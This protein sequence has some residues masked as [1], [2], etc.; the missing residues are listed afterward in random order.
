MLIINAHIV[1]QDA[2]RRIFDQGAILLREGRIAAL[3]ETAQLLRE[4]PEAER[5]DAAGKLVIPGLIDAHHHP[6]NY[7]VGGHGDDLEVS[8]L[9]YRVFYPFERCVS[10]EEVYVG[11][12]AACAEMVRSGVTCFND[13]GGYMP[14]TI[15]R[16][17]GD[18]GIRGIVNR[19]T[20]DL[21]ASGKPGVRPESTSQALQAA[22]DVVERWHGRHGGRLRA[23]FG[24]RMPI[25][26]SDDLIR[27]IGTLAR[28]YGVGVHTHAATA[29]FERDVSLKLFGKRSLD[30]YRDLGLLGPNVCAVHMG[31]LDDDEISTVV[32]SGL[33]VAHCPVAALIGAWGIMA[34]GRIPQLMEQGVTVAIGSDTNFGSGTL[35]MF[36]QMFVCAT[37][38][39]ESHRKPALVG[40]AKA[41]DMATIDAARAMLWEDEIGSLE[42]GKRADLV[43]VDNTAIEWCYPG[44][45]VVRSLVYSGSRG[46]VHSV[47]I[48]GRWVLRDRTLLTCDVAQLKHQVIDAGAAWM[49][50]SQTAQRN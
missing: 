22:V 11:A 17:M 7:L 46:D 10:E 32:Q 15:A 16:A 42:V 44:R 23:W 41:L 25:S 5:F 50:R 24:I 18:I 48:D 8:D 20:I 1:T 35:D 43:L 40:A 13:A 3:G 39:R 29:A 27:E 2:Q 9:L 34:G 36:R 47:M 28:H 12:M 38:H 26:A 45:D 4:H 19:S 30:R 37:G 49:R 6:F 33:K 31:F 21:N 14:D